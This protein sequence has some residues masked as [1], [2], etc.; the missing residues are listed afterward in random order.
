MLVLLLICAVIAAL[1]MS[2]IAL[3]QRFA[4]QTPG[5]GHEK[6]L[7]AGFIADIERRVSA[8]ELSEELAQEEQVEAARALLKASDAAPDSAKNLPSLTALALALGLAGACFAVYFAIGH[9]GLPDQPY[10][11]RLQVWTHLARTDPD[12]VPPQ[13]MAAVMRQAAATKGNDPQYWLFLGRVDMLA[14]NAYAGAKDYERARSLSPQT[15]TAWSELGEALT[16]I[17]GTTGPDA[18]KAFE[19]AIRL[20]PKDA[21]A[22]YYLGRQAVAQGRYADGRAQFTT[23]LSVMT[24]DDVSRPQVESELAAIAPAEMAAKAMNARISGMVAALEAKLKAEPEN[25]DGWARLLRAYDVLGDMAAKEKARAAMQAYYHDRP[26][27]AGDILNKSQS[28]VGAEDV[29]SMK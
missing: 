1:L 18:Q 27:V 19:A 24:A 12:Q 17:N 11:Q 2:V 7:Y 13:A 25:P 4:P 21:R 23:A 5:L 22:H 26:D 10:K 9:P 3:W 15:F 20:D 29:G 8:G 16:F 6:A 28:Q 14:G